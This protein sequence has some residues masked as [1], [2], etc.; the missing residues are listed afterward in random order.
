ML[1]SFRYVYSYKTL[2]IPE[3]EA[4]AQRISNEFGLK[5]STAFGLIF[6]GNAFP[7]Q[8]WGLYSGV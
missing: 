4:P 6:N 1:Y 2:V 3:A 8:L 7:T 5:L